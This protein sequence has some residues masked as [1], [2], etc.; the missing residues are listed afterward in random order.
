MMG[1]LYLVIGWLDVF[2]SFVIDGGVIVI[3]LLVFF[4]MC[5]V[6]VVGILVC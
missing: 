2:G 1:M 3:V 4:I 6:G 5:W